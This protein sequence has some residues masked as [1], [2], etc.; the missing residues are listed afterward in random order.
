MVTNTSAGRSASGAHELM[1]RSAHL[2]PGPALSGL[3]SPL[4]PSVLAGERKLRR[5]HG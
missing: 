2:L 1:R 4:E 3:V 5:R